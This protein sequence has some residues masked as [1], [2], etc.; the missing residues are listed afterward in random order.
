MDISFIVLLATACAEAFGKD[1]TEEDAAAAAATAYWLEDELADDVAAAALFDRWT[2]CNAV[3]TK[4]ER[5][6]RDETS[7]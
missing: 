4:V 6:M 3:V 7:K 2:G 5:N 1:A